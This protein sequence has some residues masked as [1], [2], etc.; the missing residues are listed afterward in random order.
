MPAW[1][2]LIRDVQEP[3]TPVTPDLSPGLGNTPRSINKGS[4][5]PW[6]GLAE[7]LRPHR[8]ERL[9]LGLKLS[10]DSALQSR[11]AV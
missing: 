10:R 1:G 7:G 3:C 11:V 9:P 5:E 2:Q 6:H 4:R 8:G